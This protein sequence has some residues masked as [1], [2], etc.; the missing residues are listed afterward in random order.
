MN[1]HKELDALEP[2]IIET[3]VPGPEAFNSLKQLY[4]Q[5]PFGYKSLDKN[6][7]LIEVN[8]TWLTYQT[9]PGLT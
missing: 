2:T 7:C 4:E 9:M 3:Q 1:P 6:G 8:Q 5:A